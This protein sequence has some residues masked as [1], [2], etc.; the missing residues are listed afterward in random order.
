MWIIYL[1]I[2]SIVIDFLAESLTDNYIKIKEVMK[3]EDKD[4]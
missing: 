2:G 4:K 3:K 1:I